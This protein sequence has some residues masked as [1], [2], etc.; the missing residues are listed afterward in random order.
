MKSRILPLLVFI[1]LAAGFCYYVWESR[2]QLPV[3]AA[4]HFNWQGAAD[5]WKGRD[6]LI[7]FTLAIG[8]GVPF[9]IVI[10][11]SCLRFVP[12]RF[13]NL[14]NREHWLSPEHQAESIAWVA[15]SGLWLACAV[16]V[17]MGFLHYHVVQANTVTPPKLDSSSL[18]VVASGLML[19]QLI[20]IVRILLRF[21]KPPTK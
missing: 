16:L 19:F 1:L 15:R 2:L 4:T 7:R 21:S 17:F 11:F 6:E 3:R 20:F 10:V 8:I 5:G 13:V 14:P 9:F 12:A 18:M